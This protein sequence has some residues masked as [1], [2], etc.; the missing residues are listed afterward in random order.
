MF[1]LGFDLTWRGKQYT[2]KNTPT[3]YLELNRALTYIPHCSI[4]VRTPAGPK[5]LL[6]K[7]HQ[8]IFDTSVRAVCW[9]GGLHKM[10]FPQLQPLQ[11]LTS[12]DIGAKLE[13]PAK[14]K[15]TT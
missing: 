10:I 1:N 14:V 4:L 3:R 13:H 15:V 12:H 7:F 9:F 8:A 5:E 2:G 6:T 11:R